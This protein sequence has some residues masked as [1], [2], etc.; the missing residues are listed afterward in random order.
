MPRCKNCRKKISKFLIDMYTCKCL[1]LYCGNHLYEHNCVFN[2]LEEEQSKLR[3]K[4]PK[5]TKTSTL[6]NRI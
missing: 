1:E 5:I 3:Q 4:L 6:K 2:H